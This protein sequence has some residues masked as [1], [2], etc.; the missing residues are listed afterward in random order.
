MKLKYI[1]PVILVISAF[2]CEDLE[3][4]NTDQFVVEAF[5]TAGLPIDDIKIKKTALL[6][7]D[8]LPDV[9]I[10]SAQVRVL[11]TESD[12]LLSYDPDAGKYFADDFA[13]S[14]ESFEQYRI[15]I[16]VEGTSAFAMTTVP[17]PPTGLTLSDTELIVP[18]LRLT[19][20]LR[21]QIET[22]FEEERITLSWDPIPGRSFFVVIET[23]EEQLDPILPQEIPEESLE[24][25]SSFRFISEPSEATS[26]EI[27]AIAL[28]TYGRHVAKVFTVNEEYVD[29]F[30]SATQDSRDLNEPPS[31]MSN[32][33]GIFTAFAVDSLE[34]EVSRN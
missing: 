28:E 31:N 20:A 10:T 23:Q 21:D 27:I 33:L 32:A 30:N 2:S 25:L 9:P 17:E 11:S 3:R 34:F 6:S 18:Q 13:L 22:L 15:E 26:F 7:V 24:L 16:D 12:V 19:L 8:S 14:I 4:P 29:L 5:I 1:L